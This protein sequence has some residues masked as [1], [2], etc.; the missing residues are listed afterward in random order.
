MPVRLARISH[1]HARFSLPSSRRIGR[2][3]GKETVMLVVLRLLKTLSRAIVE[4][5]LQ[6]VER[7]L[8]PPGIS[9]SPSPRRPRGC[10]VHARSPRQENKPR[11]EA[12]LGT[13][14]LAGRQA[15]M[16]TRVPCPGGS[17]ACAGALLESSWSGSGGLVWTGCGGGAGGGGGVVVTL[18]MLIEMI[19][20]C[21]ALCRPCA[22]ADNE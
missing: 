6:R 8:M 20:S 13:S 18:E 22:A 11:N 5:K 14:R 12:G 21:N 1:G 3:I 19:L 9:Y 16:L 10:M 17:G 15:M 4:A 2:V 7:E